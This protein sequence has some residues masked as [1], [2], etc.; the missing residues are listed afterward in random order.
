MNFETEKLLLSSVICFR[1]SC[2]TTQVSYL[3]ARRPTNQAL[4]SQDSKYASQG[5]DCVLHPVRQQPHR[6]TTLSTRSSPCRLLLTGCH[7]DPNPPS[8]GFLL[9][10]GPYRSFSLTL[11]LHLHVA[12]I[13]MALTALNQFMAHFPATKNGDNPIGVPV[14]SRKN[15]MIELLHHLS[16]PVSLDDC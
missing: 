8:V 16:P 5:W 4:K 10:P 11:R 14:L 13:S 2:S 6:V 15:R 1:V 9:V 12:E 7:G 3:S